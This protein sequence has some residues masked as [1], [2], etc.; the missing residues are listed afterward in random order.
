MCFSVRVLR[1]C[2]GPSHLLGITDVTIVRAWTPWP[3]V[4]TGNMEYMDAIIVQGCSGCLVY[5]GNVDV[6][7]VRARYHRAGSPMPSYANPPPPREKA[8]TNPPP[9]IAL[10]NLCQAKSPSGMRFGE[11]IPLKGHRRGSL[12]RL[13]H[14]HSNHRPRLFDTQ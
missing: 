4:S 1:G 3:L 12:T 13:W 2:S 8:K 6:I 9:P 7:I 5:I 14:R 10:C 11:D